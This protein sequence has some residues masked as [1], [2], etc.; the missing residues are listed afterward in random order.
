LAESEHIGQKSKIEILDNDSKFVQKVKTFLG[1]RMKKIFKL[2]SHFLY[3]TIFVHFYTG[4]WY[5]CGSLFPDKHACKRFS[6]NLSF[7]GF[8]P[9]VFIRNSISVLS[10]SFTIN[11]EVKSK[12]NSTFFYLFLWFFQSTLV[13]IRPQWNNIVSRKVNDKISFSKSSI[14]KLFFL[15]IWIFQF[16]RIIYLLLLVFAENGKIESNRWN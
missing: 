13:I 15:W 12:K 7:K 1:K 11:V 8:L 2:M 14:N 3:L 16:V 4:Y 9:F 5:Q 6:L 10:K